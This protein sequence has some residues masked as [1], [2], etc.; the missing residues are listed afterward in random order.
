MRVKNKRKAKYNS[1]HMV[2]GCS[3]N[4]NNKSSYSILKDGNLFNNEKARI[5]TNFFYL[6]KEAIYSKEEKRVRFR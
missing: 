3:N 6:D 1:K 5:N 2:W 4:N